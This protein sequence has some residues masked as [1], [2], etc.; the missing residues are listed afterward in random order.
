MKLNGKSPLHV[1][2][3]NN[4]RNRLARSSAVNSLYT[5]KLRR[6]G[7]DLQMARFYQVKTPCLGDE[8]GDNSLDHTNQNY[9]LYFYDL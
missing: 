3:A 1:R 9:N 4:C 8:R 7:F 2:V 6:R 5:Y